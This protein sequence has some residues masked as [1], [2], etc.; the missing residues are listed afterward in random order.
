MQGEQKIINYWVIPGIKEQYFDIEKFIKELV[1]LI[2]RQTKVPI[3]TRTRIREVCEGRQLAC[4]IL[5]KYNLSLNRIGNMF[6]IDHATVLHSIKVVNEFIDYDKIFVGRWYDVLKFANVAIKPIAINKIELKEKVEK[7]LP[8][9]CGECDAYD[10]KDRF[11]NV[12]HVRCYDTK[13]LC[14]RCLKYKIN[15]R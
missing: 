2:E 8:S 11:C 10:L 4:F 5:R 1:E 12:R 6:N 14:N 13:P 3:N 9:T 7:S 15:K